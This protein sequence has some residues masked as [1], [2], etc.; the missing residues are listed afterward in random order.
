MTDRVKI[1]V[2]VP[3][4]EADNLRAAI[5]KVGGG[6]VGE[7][8]HCSFSVSGTGRFI[9][10]YDAN[11]TIGEVNKPEKVVEERIEITCNKN[12]ASIVVEAIRVSHSYEEPAID[13]YPLL[14][15]DDL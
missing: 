10:G 12:D 4:D 7:Y 5:G 15:I 3:V 1:V 8:T 14:N 9:P 2:T 11:P 13:V 6:V